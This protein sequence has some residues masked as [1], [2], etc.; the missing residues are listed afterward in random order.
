DRFL[1]KGSRIFLDTKPGLPSNNSSELPARFLPYLRLSPLRL[2]VPQVYEWLPTASPDEVLLLL[3]YAPIWHSS[4]GENAELRAAS[5]SVGLFPALSEVWQAATP[6]RQL[7]WLGQMANLWQSLSS[8]RVVSSLLDPE[9]LRVEGGILRLLELRSDTAK[10]PISL[11]TLGQLWLQWAETAR[12]EIA[13]RMQQISQQLIQGQIHNTEQLAEQLDG[14][15]AQIGQAHA[16]NLEIATL[17]DQGPTRQRNE[18]ACYP[19]SGTETQNPALPLVI[20][21]DGIGGH[22]GGDVASNLAIEAIEQR[23]K[24]LKPEALDPVTLTVELEKAACIAN[25]QISQRNDSEQRHD[26]QRMGTTLVMGLMRGHELYVTHVGD[27]RAY[28]ITRRGCHQITLDDDVA[29]REVRLGYSAYRQALQQPSAGSLVQALGMGTSNL[30][31][32]TAQRFIVDEDSVFLFCSDGLSDNDRVESCWETEILPILEGKAD[33]TWVARRLVE[34]AN[35]LNGYDNATVG[36]LHYQIESTPSTPTLVALP[37]AEV[38]FSP[39]LGEPPT[40]QSA[41]QSPNPVTPS[42]TLETQLVRQNLPKPNPLPLLLGIIALIGLG[43]GLIAALLPTLTQRAQLPSSSP[44][45]V[46][47]TTPSPLPS[48][49]LPSLSVGSRLQLQRSPTLTSPQSSPAIGAPILL[50]SPL[51]PLNPPT[52]ANPP[53]VTS[54]TLGVIPVGSILEVLR[55]GDR[56]V[57]LR[58]CST[59]AGTS[60]ESSSVQSSGSAALP[61]ET[62]SHPAVKS[63]IPVSPSPGALV[64]PTAPKVSPNESPTV[65]PVPFLQPGQ[66]GWIREEDILPVVSLS[67]S[68]LQLQGV[69]TSPTT[70][71]L[72]NLGKSRLF[73]STSIVQKVVWLPNFWKING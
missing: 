4:T 8:E 20:V 5:N 68:S 63:E 6:L 23:M 39:A 45:P 2:H 32:P 25:D 7:N 12:P 37:L 55:I 44:S 24:V 16:R 27:S 42:S 69:C 58:V 54:Q 53:E 15:I 22:Q 65:S 38:P 10:T 13:A 73:N 17:T 48:A 61:R 67:Q 30:L 62:E 11:A 70:L 50:S 9:L 64:S 52:S 41:A 66:I 34:I 33:L 56:W 47:T 35:S 1:Y 28:W 72:P 21:C 49:I 29:S 36:L 43:A 26:R 60:P 71:N 31:Y 19:K 51:Q 3:D 14:A 57:Q 18:D 46:P 59:P 40:L